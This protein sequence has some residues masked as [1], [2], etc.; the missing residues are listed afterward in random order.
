MTITP[1]Q[2]HRRA[3]ILEKDGIVGAVEMELASQEIARL[4]RELAGERDSRK[5]LDRALRGKDE[6][7]GV[8]FAR[9]A[10]HRIDCSDLIS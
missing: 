5:C 6:A 1:E 8:L 2:L 9:L 7:M 4:Q 3:L 10:E